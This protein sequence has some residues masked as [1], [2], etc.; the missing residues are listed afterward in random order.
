MEQ[1]MSQALSS[2]STSLQGRVVIVTGGT[3]GLG[4]ATCR[5]VVRQGACLVVA[6]L[7]DKRLETAVHELGPLCGSTAGVLG[8]KVDVRSEDDAGAMA[9]AT[10]ERFGRIDALVACAGILRKRGTSPKPVTA[11]TLDE[12]NEVI[13]VNLKG[14]FL[15]NRAVLPRMIEQREGTIIN[16]SSTSGLMGRAHDG[17]YCASKFGV[18]GLTKSIADEVRSYGIKVLA[19][20]PDAI[21]TPM[22]EQNHPVPPPGN[23]L[24]PDDVADLIVFLLTQPRDT[25]LLDPVIVPLGARRRKPASRAA[26]VSEPTVSRRES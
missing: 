26:D 20:M 2:T 24:P 17:A 16:V 4:L 12:W 19:I 11:M 9:R 18:N 14:I 6:D 13:D 1:D 3:G 21:D 22:W 10:L 8:L 23:A 15:T 25:L 5:A 7:E